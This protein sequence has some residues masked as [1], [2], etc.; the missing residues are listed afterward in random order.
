MPNL[1]PDCSSAR[2]LRP[3]SC[4]RWLYADAQRRIL[5]VVLSVR[6]EASSCPSINRIYK[7]RTITTFWKILF[8]ERSFNYK[9]V[10]SQ[11]FMLK[12]KYHALFMTVTLQVR[13][14]PEKILRI[15]EHRFTWTE[16][17]FVKCQI[18]LRLGNWL[19]MNM[20]F[21]HYQHAHTV[22]SGPV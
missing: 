10:R 15:I 11:I 14:Y 8:D 9:P 13:S 19:V 4:K 5:S 20:I 12:V 17:P 22:E 7:I 16:A 18:S 1:G 21:I 3:W 6:I 2:C